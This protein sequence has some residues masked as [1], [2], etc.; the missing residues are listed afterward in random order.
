MM[1][2]VTPV[3][4]AAI[5]QI[6]TANGVPFEDAMRSMAARRAAAEGKD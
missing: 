5:E 4:Q 1:T 6:D 3:Q 2:T